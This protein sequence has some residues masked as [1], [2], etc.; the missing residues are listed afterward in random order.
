[1]ARKRVR[2]ID[3]AAAAGVSPT[4]AS[5][6][7]NGRHHSIPAA[8]RH[9]VEAAAK[10]LGYCPH[11]TARALATGRTNRIGVV[12]NT[13]ES[14]S[15]RDA[16]FRDI[17]SGILRAAP[18]YD[19]NLLFHTA[20]YADWYALG[21]DIRGG[22]TD[23]IILVGRYADDGLTVS[24]LDAEFPTVCVSYHVD[25]PCCHSVDCDNVHAARLAV[26]HLI[27]L[28]HR[29]IAILYPGVSVS[30]G[31]ERL[32]GARQALAEAGL[33][34]S[35]L[36]QIEWLEN[37]L[38]SVEWCDMV[39]RQLAAMRTD[40]TAVVCCEEARAN[41]LTEML[42]KYGV[43]L[44]DDMSLVSFNSTELS[45]HANPPLTSL[46]QP[47][48]EIGQAAVDMAVALING[49]TTQ[50]RI[51]RLPVE[52]DIRGSTTPPRTRPV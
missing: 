39:A 36:R 40:I 49:D 6:V 17:L 31:R 9:R 27:E 14:F 3:V 23:G 38:P 4:T 47:L 42:P 52:L 35:S 15:V 24:L 7:L 45:E 32:E 2:M 10:Q 11:S 16:Y 13:P 43:R 26:R 28:G 48:E 21:R 34:P 30:W 12:L 20:N 37:A 44:P 5:F 51:H 25:H 41:Y 18:S 29:D 22:S 50:D 19:C 1:M 33:S 8:T 46:R